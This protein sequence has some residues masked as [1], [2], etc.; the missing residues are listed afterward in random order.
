M[1]NMDIESNEL[2]SRHGGRH[3]RAVSLVDDQHVQ[4]VGK[5]VLAGVLLTCLVFLLILTL[6]SSS[7]AGVMPEQDPSFRDHLATGKD[8][9]MW[10]KLTSPTTVAES[11][12]AP[13]PKALRRLLQHDAHQL[14]L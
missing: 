2:L 7:G 11:Y 10:S 1:I 3:G 8:A 5:S 14:L 6:R 12:V 4:L 9:L 13:T